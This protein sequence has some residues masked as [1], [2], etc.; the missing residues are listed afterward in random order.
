MTSFAPDLR[1]LRPARMGGVLLALSALLSLAACESPD[2]E[3]RMDEFAER[4]GSTPPSDG[5]AGGAADAA[6]AGSGG[7]DAIV[8]D[9][10]N[11]CTPPDPTGEWFFALSAN[12]DREA[13]L[14]FEISMAYDGETITASGQPLRYDADP[15]TGDPSAD[16]RSPVGD[17]VPSTSA[18]DA[19]G[20]FVMDFPDVL[21]TGEA[22]PLTGRDIEGTVIVDGCIV[23]ENETVGVMRGQI[24]APLMLNLE[25][26]TFA[27]VRGVTPYTSIDPVFYDENLPYE[28]WTCE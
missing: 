25:G 27:G 10:G 7:A 23:G 19:Q 5:D 8:D 26:S 16:P 12:L 24:V 22:N 1:S 4:T 3:G 17:P 9:A 11:V 20:C 18:Y 21:V 2:P 28:P 6:D 14:Y 15:L 13:P